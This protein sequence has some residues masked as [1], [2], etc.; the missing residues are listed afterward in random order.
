MRYQNELYQSITSIENEKSYNTRQLFVAFTC[1]I[2]IT[3]SYAFFSTKSQLPNSTNIAL[4]IPDITTTIEQVEGNTPLLTEINHSEIAPTIQGTTRALTQSMQSLSTIWQEHKIKS[5]ESL[6]SIFSANELPKLDL[7]KIIHANDISYQ[8]TE[9]IQG[10]SLLIGLDLSGKLS[11]LIYRKSIFEE[12]KATRIEDGSFNVKL[13]TKPIDRLIKNAKGTIHSSLFIDGKNAGLSDNIIMQ[14]ANI[15]AWDVDVAFSLREGDKFSVIY[16]DLYIDNTMVG[17]GNILA[18]E[19]ISHG[20]AIR[21]VRYEAIDGKASYYT[22][23]GDNMRKAFLRTPIDFAR[24]SSRFNLKRKHPV[25]NRIRAHKGVDYAASSGTPIKAAGEGKIIFRGYKNG[26]GN[27]VILQHGQTYST[28]Y[29]H[30]S[31]FKQGQRTGYRVNQ[32][33]TIGYV[34]KT[35]LASGPHLHYEFRINGAHRNP[36]TV[37]LPN[38]SPIINK[39]K[40]DFLDMSGPLFEQLKELNSVNVASTE[41]IE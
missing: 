32:G 39:Y 1:S 40:A 12:L 21:A 2:L 29:A 9:I 38:A 37:K 41:T 28:L 30:M 22:P 34:G 25:L 16:E 13:I 15:F 7:Y 4:T 3:A 26:Y 24:I 10:K 33:D 5:G 35:G 31:K 23:S 14:L 27:V 36:L 11:H 6:S 18:A 19:L 17:A 8:F 20:K